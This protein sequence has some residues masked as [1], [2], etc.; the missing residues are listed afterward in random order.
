MALCPFRIWVG[1]SLAKTLITVSWKYTDSSSQ[2]KIRVN[3]QQNGVKLTVS[4]RPPAC[5]M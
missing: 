1:G 4:C 3:V 2:Q 5:P